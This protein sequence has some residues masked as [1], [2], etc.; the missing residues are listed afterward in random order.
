MAEKAQK[1]NVTMADGSIEAFSQKSKIKSV[2]VFDVNHVPVGI[3]FACRNGQ[4]LEVVFANLAKEVMTYAP[5]HGIKQKLLDSFAV[6]EDL[7]VDDRWT[8]LQVMHDQLHHAWNAGRRTMGPRPKPVINLAALTIAMR[9][10]Y[11]AKTVEEIVKILNDYTEPQRNKLA[12]TTDVLPLYYA[13][14]AK[15]TP[16]DDDAEELL[17]AFQDDDEE[18]S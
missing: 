6:K 13:E 17:G 11:P 12:H 7:P 14:V 4:R 10:L 18:E 16:V 5:G 8:Q 3:N 1:I 9:Q 15:L 2:M